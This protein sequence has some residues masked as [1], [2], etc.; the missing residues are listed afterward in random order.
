MRMAGEVGNRHSVVWSV[1]RGVSTEFHVY[2]VSHLNVEQGHT[3]HLYTVGIGS[4]SAKESRPLALESQHVAHK[5]VDASA[6]PHPA[7]VM[8]N[9]YIIT[10]CRLLTLPNMCL[11]CICYISA[12]PNPAQDKL[13]KTSAA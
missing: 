5:I 11:G 2:I 10:S 9:V 1:V 6:T 3:S 4:T 12:D 7:K 8:L 13:S